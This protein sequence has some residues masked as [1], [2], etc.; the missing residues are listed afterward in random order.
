MRGLRCALVSWVGPSTHSKRQAFRIGLTYDLNCPT[1]L[2]NSVNHVK[3]LGCQSQSK[4]S[5]ALAYCIVAWRYVQRVTVCRERLGNSFVAPCA[6]KCRV[7]VK[8]MIMPRI[9]LLDLLPP[10]SCHDFDCGAL[11]T[12][13][14]HQIRW[15]SEA[16]SCH[17]V[18]FAI[19]MGRLCAHL[20]MVQAIYG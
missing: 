9:D 19:R 1:D 12:G 20:A 14:R 8:W 17:S 16:S 10:A 18:D 6:E 15:R 11:D 2:D 13:S 5:A 4:C 3:V 7:E